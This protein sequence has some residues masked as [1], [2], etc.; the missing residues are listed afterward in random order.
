QL[1][2]HGEMIKFDGFLRVYAFQGAYEQGTDESEQHTAL[3]PQLKVGQQLALDYM[4]ARERFT[5]APARYSEAS[6]VRQLEEQGIGRPSTYAPIIATIQQRGYVIKESR[7][8]KER[9]YRVLTLQDNTVSQAVLKEVVGTE[10]N[11]LF[12]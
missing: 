12:P 6:L 8:G 4:Q 3:L 5:K 10:K 9:A 2:A 11:K 7:E 1:I